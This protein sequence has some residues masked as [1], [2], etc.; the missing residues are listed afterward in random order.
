MD[1]AYGD[2]NAL[3][4]PLWGK[5][6][7]K[8]PLI[9]AADDVLTG[10]K[11]DCWRETIASPQ[12]NEQW[13]AIHFSDTELAALDLPILLTDGWYDLTIGPID[14]FTRLERLQPERSDR[15]LLVGPWDHYQTY[16]NSQPGANSG[17]RILPD[18]ASIDLVAQ[19]L[20]FFDRYLKQT[21][22]SVVQESR[23]RIYITGAEN[24]SVNNWFNFPTF[25]VPDTVYKRLYLHSEGDARSFPGDGILNWDQ[26]NDEPVDHYLYDPVLPTHFQVETSR[27]RREVEIRSDVLTYTSGPLK[28]PLTILGDI[29][30][31]LYAA[32]DAPDTDWFAVL[33][34]VYP[35]GQSKSFHYAPP[36]FRARY[37]EGF[38]GD[39][40]L[41]PG[42]PEEFCLPM[43]PAGHQIAAGNRLRL[44]IFS[45][46][47]PEYEPNSNTG[48]PLA[49]DTEVRVAR[50][51]VFH[52]T[53]RPTHIVLP[54]FT[55]DKS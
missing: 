44:S 27:D 48:L 8:R 33:T 32:S 42:K 46:A 38:D 4:H 17:D 21:E 22:A 40:F 20:A 47:F 12:D 54:T 16:S 34:E 45:A 49:A 6:F 36:A 13:R 14:F 24:S 41:T 2:M 26:P 37:R 10:D 53:E 15:Y 9:N 51:T 52:D 30:L 29:K 39:V 1:L 5:A 19:R 50:Q 3:K 28:E 25:P 18:N 31:H 35:D 43:G 23:A 11:R 7:R 55:L